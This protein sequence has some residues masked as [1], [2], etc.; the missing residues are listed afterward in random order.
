MV[1][2]LVLA[3]AI[4][5]WG[6]ERA[7]RATRGGD[8]TAAGRR[9]PVVAGRERANND[10]SFAL[11]RVDDADLGVLRCAWEGPPREGVLAALNGTGPVQGGFDLTLRL[12]PGVWSLHFVPVDGEPEALGNVD[13]VAGEVYT[14]AL[15]VATPVTVTVVDPTGA[16]VEG[17]DVAGCDGA[18]RSDAEG[19]VILGTTVACRVRATWR[20]G[21]LQRPGDTAFA[22]AFVRTLEL[23]VDPRPVA[24]LGI[25]FQPGP[26]GVRVLRVHPATPA[27]DAG[28]VDGDLIVEL[29]GTPVAGV[30]QNEFIAVGTGVEGTVADVVVLRGGSRKHIAVRRERIEPVDTGG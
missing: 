13:V 20:D 30:G 11:D 12:E 5:L 25:Q 2:L 28:L 9:P 23:T 22:S 14:C 24:G 10:G 7:E 27:E 8:R 17:A 1:S 6:Y 18:G 21:I 3:L 26:D 16:P 15:G 19:R 4:A 29:D